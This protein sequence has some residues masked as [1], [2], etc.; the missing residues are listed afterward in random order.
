MFY[1][2]SSLKSLD[3]FNFYTYKVTDISNM[4][5]DCSSLE[6]L[7]IINIS[8][9]AAIYYRKIFEGCTS[10]KYIYYSYEFIKKYFNN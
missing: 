4:F 2:C 7:N 10:L 1:G 8:L 9:G 5:F 3:L 6:K